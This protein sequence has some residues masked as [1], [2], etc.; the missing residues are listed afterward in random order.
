MIVQAEDI[1]K[2]IQLSEAD[3]RALKELLPDVAAR[4]QVMNISVSQ[5]RWLAMGVH[6][7]AFVDRV[8]T[9]EYLPP[10][11]KSVLAQVDTEVL[12]IS[13]AILGKYS[14]QFNREVDDTE[15]L[16]LAVHLEAA[17]NN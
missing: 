4:M 7:A 17:R 12:N 3:S 1:I 16:L 6:L 9:G 10:V 15:A 11:D 5:E 8:R 14:N 2:Q 13:R